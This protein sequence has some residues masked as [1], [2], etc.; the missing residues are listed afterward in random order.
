MSNI[1]QIEKHNPDKDHK[2]LDDFF[3]LVLILS[4]QIITN[5]ICNSKFIKFICITPIKTLNQYH[6]Y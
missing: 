5:K 6:S 3:F 1:T 4:I 2:I